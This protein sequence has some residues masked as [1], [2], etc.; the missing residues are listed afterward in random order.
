MKEPFKIS[1]VIPLYNEV[2]TIAKIIGRIKAEDFDKE[3][4]IVDDFSTDGSRQYVESLRDSDIKV[5]LHDRNQGKGA[6]LRTGFQHITGDIAI[7][8]DADLEYDP[9]DYHRLIKPIIDGRADV[10]YG[11]RFRGEYRRVLLFWHAVG[12]KLVNLISNMFTNLNLTDMET[13]YKLFKREIIKS[14]DIEE[15]RFGIEPELTAKVA[16]KNCRIYEVGI[17]YY[18]RSYEEGKKI[19]WRDGVRAIYVI[20]KYGIFKRK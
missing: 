13:C 1:V 16:R 18:G 4:I 15:V 8:Q 17:S 7:I 6:A 11:S 9:H 5:F 14:I 20:L 12:N 19:N 10:V 2:N 3:I